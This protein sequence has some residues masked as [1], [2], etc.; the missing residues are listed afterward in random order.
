[1]CSAP[2][3]WISLQQDL[4]LRELVSPPDVKALITSMVNESVGTC[5]CMQVFRQAL[6]YVQYI[7]RSPNMG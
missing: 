6:R 5:H 1:M 4:K 7:Y 3:T 2:L